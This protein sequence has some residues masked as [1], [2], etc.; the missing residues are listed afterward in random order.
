M[1]CPQ[2]VNI[3]L[4]LVE[5]VKHVL[6]RE[7][8]PIGVTCRERMCKKSLHKCV[9]PILLYPEKQFNYSTHSTV[10]VTHIYKMYIFK[11]SL[12]QDSEYSFLFS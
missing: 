11:T 12:T 9:F 2:E 8:R 1:F 5:Q 6:I 7:T 10:C 3:N 4:L